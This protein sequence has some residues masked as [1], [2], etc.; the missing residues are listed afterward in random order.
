M[1]AQIRTGRLQ[2]P[3]SPLPGS[4][5]HDL[6][7]CAGLGLSERQPETVSAPTWRERDSPS[8][9]RGNASSGARSWAPLKVEA[10][11]CKARAQVPPGHV[12]SHRVRG[13]FCPPNLGH[14]DFPLAN[15][16]LEPEVS[17]F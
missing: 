3:P 9:K 12:L 8:R 15:F 5:N 2:R 14:D 16:P 10:Y 4:C 11:T 17:N 6:T 13:V 1:I 7:K